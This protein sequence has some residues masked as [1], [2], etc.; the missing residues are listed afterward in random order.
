MKEVSNEFVSSINE[1]IFKGYGTQSNLGFNPAENEKQSRE[2][3]SA[4]QGKFTAAPAAG[5]AQEPKVTGNQEN[6]AAAAT[7]A[8]FHKADAVYDDGPSSPAANTGLPSNIGNRWSPPKT[9]SDSKLV[10]TPE[11]NLNENPLQERIDKLEEALATIVEA[12]RRQL[13]EAKKPSA[14]LTSKKKKKVVKKARKGK[15]IGK[16]GKNF[17][18]VAAKA[19]GGEKG[20][21]IAAA[22]MW[23]NMKR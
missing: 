23:K 10:D 5:N 7:A 12:M 19:G 11:T 20:E 13:E 18:K 16:K 4:T 22:A 1:N 9:L 3:A 6:A 8:S 15:D 14:G 17:A 21:K 2:L